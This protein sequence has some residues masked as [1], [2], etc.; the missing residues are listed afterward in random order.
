MTTHVVNICAKVYS[1]FST[2]LRRILYQA[3]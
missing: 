3:K 2:K 1:N